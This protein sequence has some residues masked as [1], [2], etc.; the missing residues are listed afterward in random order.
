MKK[1]KD[2]GFYWFVTCKV[3]GFEPIKYPMMCSD[4]LVDDD[5]II[6][7]LK[8]SVCYEHRDLDFVGDIEKLVFFAIDVN[9]HKILIEPLD[10]YDFW[11][12]EQLEDDLPFDKE[13]LE[14]ILGFSF[15]SIFGDEKGGEKKSNG[16]DQF[17]TYCSQDDL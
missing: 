2:S 12:L 14:D 1:T 15:V 16:K 9:E 7:Y 10:V 3:D 4:S 11:P 8:E 17:R 5:A 13:F 6:N